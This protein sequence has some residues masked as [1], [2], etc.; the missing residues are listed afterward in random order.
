[1]CSS[2]PSSSSSNSSSSGRSSSSS[3]SSS[4]SSNSGSSCLSSSSS[5]ISLQL[6][7]E[8]EAY[9]SLVRW[10]DAAILERLLDSRSALLQIQKASAAAYEADV[11]AGSKQ[12]TGNS[13]S[14][15]HSSNT[16]SSDHSGRAIWPLAFSIEQADAWAAVYESLKALLAKHREMRS[17]RFAPFSAEV[18]CALNDFL[19]ELDL[20]CYYSSKS[21]KSSSSGADEE[22]QQQQERPTKKKGRKKRGKQQRQQDEEQ[23]QRRRALEEQQQQQHRQ[24]RELQASAVQARLLLHELWQQQEVSHLW[25]LLRELRLD[26][27]WLERGAAVGPAGTAALHALSAVARRQTESEEETL[28]ADLGWLLLALNHL[29]TFQLCRMLQGSLRLVLDP[30]ERL[31]IHRIFRCRAGA[32]LAQRRSAAVAADGVQQRSIF[33]LV[34]SSSK[35]PAGSS[36]FRI[37]GKRIASGPTVFFSRGA[38]DYDR[39]WRSDVRPFA[40]AK[41]PQVNLLLLYEQ[42][43]ALR[44][45]MGDDEDVDG[46]QERQQQRQSV[47]QQRSM[48]LLRRK[49]LLTF[50]IPAALTAMLTDLEKYIYFSAFDEEQQEEEKQQREERRQQRLAGE[51]AVI[52]PTQEEDEDL[53]LL[54]QQHKELLLL[55]QFEIARVRDMFALNADN[56]PKEGESAGAANDSYCNEIWQLISPPPKPTFLS[57]L[58]ESPRRHFCWTYGYLLQWLMS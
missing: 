43:V 48:N 50:G 32:L 16:S 45:L 39:L 11:A 47:Q 4:R 10:G 25:Q 29:K 3:D 40:V 22:Q 37:S 55:L 20:L 1:M 7:Q 27:R 2:S 54:Q 31:L 13:N 49:Q 53:V 56:K 23:Q 28:L 14:S 33:P 18:S 52:T 51:K 44:S 17:W 35:E 38:A 46:Q 58:F 15:N 42:L 41:E 19:L 6:R 30:N 5:S 34:S 21:S 12:R 24:Q 26:M 8:D 9:W 36:G 57:R